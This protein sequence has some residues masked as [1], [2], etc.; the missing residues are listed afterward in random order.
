MLQFKVF[1]HKWYIIE[2]KVTL[3]TLITIHFRGLRMTMKV[4]REF[5]NV[6]GGLQTSSEV[7]VYNLNLK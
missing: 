4:V 6:L 3:Y 7:Y 1:L 5:Y 2:F